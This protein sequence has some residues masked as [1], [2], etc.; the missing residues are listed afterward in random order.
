MANKTQVLDSKQINQKI[1][2]IT[3]QIIENNYKQSDLIVVGINGNGYIFAE[4]IHTII[5]QHG[6][7][8]STLTELKISKKSHLDGK[9]SLSIDE[10]QIK[11]KV[12]VLVDDVINSGETMSFAV[13]FIL[14]L[15]PCSIQTA[16]L[17]D[18]KHRKFPIKS[19]YMGKELSTTLQD[20]I[21]VEVINGEME[22]FLV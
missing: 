13:R 15:S 12:V 10:N 8:D 7:L 17:V 4:K 19:N 16:V 3:R 11:N 9:E 5:S 20:R 1:D 21:D 14:G 18:R 6:M 22:A 2:R